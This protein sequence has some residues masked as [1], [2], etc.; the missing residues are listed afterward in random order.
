MTSIGKGFAVLMITFCAL[1]A[2]RGEV[3]FGAGGGML[4]PGFQASE[5]YGS[6]FGAGFG[7]DLLARHTLIKIDSL[8]VIDARYGFRSYYSDIDL[9]TNSVTRFRYTYLVIGITW[10]ALRISDYQIYAGAAASLVTAKAQQRYVDDVTESLML[11]EVL[12]GV[13]WEINTNYN[14]FAEVGIQFGAIDIT[15]DVLSLTG[16][17]LL[18]GGTMFLTTQEK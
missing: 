13:E 8:N 16:M 4:Y 3:G 17:R 6:R 12:M 7:F 1:G 2:L 14:L 11:P 9:A 5:R 18:I 10:D 15:S